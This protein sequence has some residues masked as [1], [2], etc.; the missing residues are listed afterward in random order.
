MTL[1]LKNSD[2]PADPQA[3][4]SWYQAL[5]EIKSG[6]TNLL[7]LHTEVGKNGLA[8]EQLQHLEK[9]IRATHSDLGK[10]LT[11]LS[12]ES[13]VFESS[14]II[15]VFRRDFQE[16]N[17][18]YCQLKTK[19]SGEPA[20]EHIFC[21]CHLS[22]KTKSNWPVSSPVLS[23][24]ELQ[25]PVPQSVRATKP[26]LLI[27][28][29]GGGHGHLSATKAMGQNAHGHYHILVANTLE[30]TLAPSDVLRKLTLNLSQE[31]LYNYLLKNEKFKILKLI[32][33]GG[34]MYFRLQQRK[35]EELIRLEVLRN[36]PD[37]LI[38]CIPYLNPMFL[39]VAKEFQ[40]PLLIVTTDLDSTIF[41]S[42][43]TP[44]TCDLNYPYYRFAIAYDSPDIHQ[45]VNSV[46]PKERIVVSGFPVRPSFN[47]VFSPE[48]ITENRARYGIDP[49]AKVVLVMM[50]GNAGLAIENYARILADIQDSEF[51]ENE[52]D[53]LHVLCICGKLS[54]Y[55]DQQMF[56]AINAMKTK[57]PRVKIQAIPATSE[58]PFLMTIAE[59]LITK[60][61]GCTV[62]EAISKKLPMIFHAP[63]ALMDWEVFNMRFCIQRNFGARF[64]LHSPLGLL[65]G[66]EITKNKIRLL[67]LLKEA[68]KRR[69]N[70]TAKMRFE[71]KDFRS[72]FKNLV[73]SLLKD[74]ANA[75]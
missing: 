48:E 67:P 68:M 31:K 12:E 74:V 2:Q 34:P 62:N 49:K 21:L 25:G 63:F 5:Q 4:A 27:F 44:K 53:H 51:F 33:S 45:I 22:A 71:R 72:E 64:K 16:I 52:E 70:E 65:T 29:C 18:I 56:E 60:P 66:G 10:W 8:L 6:L 14:A 58:I 42:G 54:V 1:G 37:M 61:G 20:D 38:S 9:Q 36:S 59:V 35:I 23:E 7:Q 46:I 32:T 15:G 43:M 19:L 30:E 24:Q 75:Q 13:T 11:D 39:N 28:T 40:L 3:S 17:D 73:D 41:I 69:Q 57:S 50:G 47:Q 26:S 55:E